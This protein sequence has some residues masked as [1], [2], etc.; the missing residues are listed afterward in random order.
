M[1]T[2]IEERVLEIDKDKVIAKLEELGAKK[3]GDWHQKR[4]VYDFIPKRENEWIRLRTNGKETT[5]TYKNIE[6]KDISGTKELEIVVSDFEET[7]QLLKIMGYTP[8]SFQENLRTRYYLD[9][10]EIDIDTWPLIPTY[11]EIEGNSVEDVKR[12]EKLLELNES[13][14]TTMNCQDIYLEEYGIDINQIEELKF[15]ENENDSKPE[16]IKL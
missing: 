1:N 5:L 16:V 12:V 15:D 3:I 6:S 7:N 11:L 14:V 10:I 13:K 2:E 8:R 9:H 4:Y